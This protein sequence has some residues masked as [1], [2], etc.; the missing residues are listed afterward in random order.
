MERTPARRAGARS[1]PAVRRVASGAGAALLLAL[2]LAAATGL[3]LR[4]EE[5]QAAAAAPPQGAASILAVGDTGEEPDLLGRVP[6]QETVAE[7]LVAADRAGPV[8]ALVLLGDNFYP[9]G[10]REREFKD[11]LRANVVRPYC[12]FLALTDRGRGSLEDDCPVPE[13]ERHPVPLLAVLGNHDYKER[14]SP[15]LQHKRIPLYLGNW[16][17]PD[18]EDLAAVH[19]LPGGL[20]VVLLQSEEIVRGAETARLVETLR[21]ARGPWRVVAAH[22]PIADPGDGYDAGYARA[23][24]RA[25]AAAGVPVHLFLAGHEHSLQVVAPEEGSAPPLGLVAGGGYEAKELE[26]PAPDRLFGAATAGFARVDVHPGEEGGRLEAT[27][28]AV[29][30]GLGGGSRAT[31]VARFAVAPDARFRE[32]PLHPRG[33]AAPEV[34]APR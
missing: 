22:H 24:R 7:A 28:W 25:I 1:G 4:Q 8:A 19:E 2:V 26:S 16:S 12:H 6:G 11:R 32:L 23:V 29:D 21:R 30:G 3:S 10:L 15:L 34:R 33:S 18:T 27:L 14:E 31:L 20:S 13:E 17:L 9:E 5:A